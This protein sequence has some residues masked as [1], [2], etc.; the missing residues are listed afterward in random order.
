MAFFYSSL[1]SGQKS[2]ISTLVFVSGICSTLSGQKSEILVFVPGSYVSSTMCS[3][4]WFRQRC[5]GSAALFL[6]QSSKNDAQPDGS[7][8][9]RRKSVG[10][11]LLV[12]C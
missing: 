8:P 11:L 5:S 10:E 1:G 2:E 6:R 4:M 12:R 3:E 9:D 7:W